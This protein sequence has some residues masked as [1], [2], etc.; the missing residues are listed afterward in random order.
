MLNQ[1]EKGIDRLSLTANAINEKTKLQ[2]IMLNNLDKD[3]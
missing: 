3:I 2:G 1:L